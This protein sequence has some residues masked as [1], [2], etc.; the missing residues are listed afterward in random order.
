MIG[1]GGTGM[2]GIAEQLIAMNFN[3]SGSDMTTS[4]ATERLKQLGASIY[5]EHIADR[6]KDHDVSYLFETPFVMTMSS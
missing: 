2:A 6:V 4:E 5:K 1:I 3:V